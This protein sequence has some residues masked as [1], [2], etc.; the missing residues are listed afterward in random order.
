[1]SC[2]FSLRLRRHVVTPAVCGAAGSSDGQCSVG[3]M[4]ARSVRGVSEERASEL[5]MDRGQARGRLEGRKREVTRRGAGGGQVR[6]A[7]EESEGM[8]EA[9]AQLLE[10]VRAA[11]MRTHEV[12]Q[13]ESAPTR[14][15]P[16]RKT[17]RRFAGCH[18]GCGVLS[19]WR[20]VIVHGA[21]PPPSVFS[22]LFCS[23]LF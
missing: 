3:A 20:G 11:E 6:A 17:Q 5:Q 15:P 10:R 19:Q 9:N 21:C 23:V 4:R 22:F 12:H 14:L 16:K 8:R 2:R 18:R 13:L 1:M 7:R